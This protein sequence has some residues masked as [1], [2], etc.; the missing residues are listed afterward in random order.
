M[1]DRPIIYLR[2]GEIDLKNNSLDDYYSAINAVLTVVTKYL[3]VKGVIE[4][5]LFVIDLNGKNFTSLPIDATISIIK[6]LSIV[7]SMYLGKMAIINTNYLM[8]LTYL[9][10]KKFIHE[11]TAKKI[12]LLGSDEIQNM[13]KFVHPN[14]LENKYSGSVENLPVYWPPKMASGNDLEE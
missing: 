6:K 11:E 5:Y 10:I 12:V 14:Q 1:E 7:Y 2:I 4:S 8:K 9:T 3:F 13:Q